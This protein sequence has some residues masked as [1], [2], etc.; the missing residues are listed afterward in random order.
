MEGELDELSNAQILQEK[1]CFC[2][3]RQAG[4]DIPEYMNYQGTKI[5]TTM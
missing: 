2:L 5:T 1:P 3:S 4:K